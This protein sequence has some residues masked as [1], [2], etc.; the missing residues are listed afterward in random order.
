MNLR[1]KLLEAS[2]LHYESHIHKHVM[3]V[4]VI[5]ANPTGIPDHTDVMDAIEKEIAIIDEYDSK[6]HVLQK[7][8]KMKDDN[9]N[10]NGNNGNGNGNGG[11]EDKSKSTTTTSTTESQTQTI[12]AGAASHV[13]IERPFSV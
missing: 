6:L 1:N 12:V 8:F 5:L 7:Y 13:T 3:N 2:R 10:G 4:E 11:N 9:G